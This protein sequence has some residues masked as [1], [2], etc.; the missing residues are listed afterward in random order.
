MGV[1][2]YI[3]CVYGVGAYRV[4]GVGKK[5]RIMWVKKDVSCGYMVWVH[6]GYMMWVKQDVSCG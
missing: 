3:V 6:I 4:Y 2:L 1:M 5:G